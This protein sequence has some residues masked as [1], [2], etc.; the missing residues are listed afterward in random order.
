M[1]FTLPDYL[2]PIICLLAGIA[3]QYSGLDIRLERL[4]Y[5]S[6]QHAWPYKDLWLTQDLLHTAGRD[7]IAV[8]FV[9]VILFFL[10]TFFVARLQR[11]RRA[12]GYVLLAGLSGIALVAV[13]KDT[14][15]IY[16]PWDLQVFGGRY[17]TIHLFDPVAANLPAG[18]AFPAGHASGG[19]AL[20]SFYF[21]ARSRDYRHRYYLL[22]L[23]LGMG[24]LLGFA[25]QMR[26]AHM[27]SH[28]LFSLAI[29]WSSC[30]IWAAL[31]LSGNKQAVA[32]DPA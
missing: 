23:G 11:H 8:I 27:L 16:T 15:H 14:V 9:G 29:C 6:Q 21:L 3:S 28:D 31:L 10:A 19:Y 24:V 22:A 30:L 18:H 26:G 32:T 25:Q 20:L 17:P 2:F 1:K 5:D 13:L 7:L 4:F 12:A